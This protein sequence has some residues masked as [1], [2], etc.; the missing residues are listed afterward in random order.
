MTVF[1]PC[2]MADIR[3][4]IMCSPPKSCSLDPLPFSLFMT[5]L[6]HILPFLQLV[7]NLSLRTG[8]VP[9]AKKH[10]VVTPILKK[11]NLDPDDVKNYRP[12][13]NLSFL[14]K[15][16]ERLVSKQLTTYLIENKLMP[17]FQSAYRQN[18]STETAVLQILSDVY[19]AADTGMVTLLAMLDLSAAF[20]TVDHQTLLQRLSCSYGLGGV[21]LGWIESFLT[22][23]TQTV[24][25]AEQQS[26][27]TKLQY[28]VPQGSVLGPLLFNLYT[29]DII[30]IAASF[31]ARVHCY[32]DDVQL[33]MHCS[34]TDTTFAVDRLL[35]CIAAIDGWM[36]S[37]R[38]Q[39]KRNSSG[40]ALVNSLLALTFCRCIS[41]MARSLSHLYRHAHWASQLTVS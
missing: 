18:H 24:I 23:R 3:R 11:P 5:S 7:C 2:T 27:Q 15:L 6:E 36:S 31:D 40:L 30:F 21:V 16:I 10:A 22:D 39:I 25:F 12:I 35:A 33:Y 13:S 9:S 28:G 38:M 32:A 4:T 20:D 1:T 29:A 41:M 14:S 34:A 17:V 19:D 37:N 8:L 26:A